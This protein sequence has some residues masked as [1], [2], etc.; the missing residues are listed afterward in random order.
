MKRLLKPALTS[1]AFVVSGLLAW[2]V[3]FLLS[4]AG[5]ETDQTFVDSPAFQLWVVVAAFAV[6]AFVHTV[7][8][9][10]NE[11]RDERLRSS[12][13]SPRTYVGLY[14]A[15]AGI[16]VA[17][18]MVAGRGGPDVPVEYWRLLSAA[19]LLLGVAGAGPWIVPVWASHSLLSSDR[20]EIVALPALVTDATAT[21]AL[22]RMLDQLLDIRSDI[23]AAVGRLLVLVLGA[24]LLS[25]ALRNALV[26]DEMPE[27]KF[28]ASAVL[29]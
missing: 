7:W 4:N 26:P 18:L 25:G 12:T 17:A 24:V 13:P 11:L 29:V 8:S 15:F 3:V 27:A 14:V 5:D 16:T 28:P 19:L 6:V 1:I 10:I 22:D 9:G 21:A 2:S 20:A 23:A